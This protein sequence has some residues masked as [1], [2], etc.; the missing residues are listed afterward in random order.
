V[1][2]NDDCQII[3][4]E[5]IR[6]LAENI[7]NDKII[8]NAGRMVLPLFEGG[9]RGGKKKLVVFLFRSPAYR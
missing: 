7:I 4:S 8:S 3:R 1:F 5:G 2:F 6:I 9:V